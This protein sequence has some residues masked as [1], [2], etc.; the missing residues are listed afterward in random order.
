MFVVSKVQTPTRLLLFTPPLD[1]LDDTFKCPSLWVRVLSV[2]FV[3]GESFFHSLT[4]SLTL[5]HTHT[6]T[7]TRSNTGT[8][9][10]A[11]SDHGDTVAVKNID[12]ILMRKK[13]KE[14]DVNHEARYSGLAVSIEKRE[15]NTREHMRTFISY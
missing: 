2:R 4:H 12:K 15:L 1:S 9:Y 3:V 6:H 14:S 5:T 7:L 10:A 13:K 11:I 8:V